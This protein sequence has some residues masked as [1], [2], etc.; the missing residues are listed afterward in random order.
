MYHQP[1]FRYATNKIYTPKTMSRYLGTETTIGPSPLV[2][3]SHTTDIKYSRKTAAEL[4]EPASKTTH[5]TSDRRHT[6]DE[7]TTL[8]RS[9]GGKWQSSPI[10]RGPLGP[11]FQR[12]GAGSSFNE[13]KN[14]AEGSEIGRRPSNYYS[15]QYETQK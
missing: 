12:A 14:S 4:A 15:P 11:D 5:T 10:G 3:V 7:S 9:P 13:R 6:C 2:A 1:L 8:I